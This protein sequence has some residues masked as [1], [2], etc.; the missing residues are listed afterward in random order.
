M[1]TD[2]RAQKNPVV[3]TW[4]LYLSLLVSGWKTLVRAGWK[5]FAVML[6]FY[7]LTVLV[8][9]PLIG[10]LFREALRA[11]GMVAVDF[12]TMAIGRG[13]GISLALLAVLGLVAFWSVAIQFVVLIVM[14][15]RAQSGRSLTVRAVWVDSKRVFKKLFELSSL[16]LALYLFVVLPLTG[17]GFVDALASRIAVPQFISGEAMKDTGTAIAWVTFMALLFLANL[18]FALSLPIF[19]TTQASGARSM[20]IS[21]RLMGLE[22]ALALVAA[23]VTVGVGAAVLTAFFAFIVVLPTAGADAWAPSIAPVTASFGLSAA[24][25]FAALVAGVATAAML[26]LTL[27]LT[28]VHR[29]QMPADATMAHMAPNTPKHVS[30]RQAGWI[31][32]AVGVGTTIVFGFAGISTMETLSQQPTTVI[33]AHRGYVGGG[34]ENSLGALE[35]AADVNADMVE[36]DVMQTKDGEFVVI[37]DPQ[38]GRLA[39]LHKS[40]KDMTLDELTQVEIHDHSGHTDTIPSLEE[41]VLRAKELNM[42]LLIEIKM[43]GLDSDDHVE[44]LVE[45]LE[46]LDAMDGNIF[47]S[48]D[49][50]SVETLKTIRPD[51]TVGYIMPF[52]G[53]GLPRTPADFIV[54]EEWTA[55]KNMQAAAADAGLGFFV[56][57]VDAP[58]NQREKLR[59]GVDGIITDKPVAALSSRES[60]RE[61]TGLAHVLTDIMSSFLRF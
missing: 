5:L 59:R 18:K 26:A 12:G 16:P 17:F 9:M 40:V 6:A 21:W 29:G 58:E 20:R 27:I 14:L 4:R 38:L 43:G 50:E 55:T 13:F 24:H 7:A 51:T 47:H 8:S 52:A 22:S 11:N 31:L 2:V 60:M 61:E 42:P 37:H 10:W 36:M 19:A 41:Y 54:V 45:Q 48:L 1:T 56:W 3:D 53:D 39:S 57:T 44:R 34:V 46:S 28:E 23:V 32:L 33:L 25:V 30:N 35:A 15:R 49:A